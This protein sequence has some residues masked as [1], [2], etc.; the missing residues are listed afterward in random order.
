MSTTSDKQIG[1]FLK[2]LGKN[3]L[4]K[5]A[6]TFFECLGNCHTSIFFVQTCFNYFFCYFRNNLPSFH[7]NIWSHCWQVSNSSYYRALLGVMIGRVWEREKGNGSYQHCASVQLSRRKIPLCNILFVEMFQT[8]NISGSKTLDSVSRKCLVA[9]SVILDSQTSQ[10]SKCHDLG[11]SNLP[12]FRL[13]FKW[14]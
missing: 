5:V 6:Q 2:I 9:W 8:K 4:T 13:K 14:D 1:R 3:Y 12:P 11:H 7:S 10:I